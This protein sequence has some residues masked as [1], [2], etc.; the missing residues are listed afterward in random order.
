MQ[1]VYLAD[2]PD[3]QRRR[4]ILQRLSLREGEPVMKL[5]RRDF[6]GTVSSAAALTALSATT[7]HHDAAEDPLGVRTDFRAAREYTYLDTAHI[8]LIASPVLQAGRAWLDARAE[9]PID[10]DEMLEKTDETRNRFARLI[11]VSNDEIGFLFSTTEGENVVTNALD[12]QP[13]D[14]IVIDNL[15]FPSTP[16]IYRH[17]EETKRI[18]LRIVSH[19]DGAVPVEDF[20]R[21]VDRK[22]RLIS[23]AWVSN[24]NGFRH[25]MP[26]LADLA[27]AHGAYLYADAIQ[28]VGMSPLD[29]R[30]SG[31]DF[32]C[33]GSYKW[34]MADFGV[35]PFFV[36]K[37]LLDRIRSDRVGWNLEREL[38]NYQYKHFRSAKKY[39][40]SCLAFGEVYKLAAALAYLESVGLEKI[41]AHTQ[42]L[43]DQ[44][45]AGLANRGF[46]I[47][48]PSGTHS[49]IL[50]FY[51][52]QSPDAAAKIFDAAGVKISTQN[53][54]TTD[55]EDR[56]G[57][58]VSRVRVAVSLFNNAADIQ[59][60]L[61]ATSKVNMS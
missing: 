41:E 22:T 21:L 50:S 53:G 24:L 44:L 38:G 59:R 37:E 35:A 56:T 29:V 2:V 18:E 25:D 58:S 55:E 26:A 40:F 11:N 46:R 34:L 30:A 4:R 39:E 10:V 42:S 54:D 17:L 14:N 32:L 28:A 48:T 49:S 45:R 20:A 1:I 47:F 9:H 51:I 33:S 31:V 61:D 5:S 60:L 13:G 52:H 57:S 6:V 12:F 3:P 27:H 16:I 19:R 8:G 23:V 7:K 36:R 43:T 15:G